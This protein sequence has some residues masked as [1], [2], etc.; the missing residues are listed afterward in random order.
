MDKRLENVIA[1]HAFVSNRELKSNKHGQIE[2][3]GLVTFKGSTK[4]SGITT[5]KIANEGYEG[6]KIRWRKLP[7]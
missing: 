7:L 6:G 2:F 3:N 4:A 5:I 1:L